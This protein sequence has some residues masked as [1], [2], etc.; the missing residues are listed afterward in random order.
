M[1]NKYLKIHGDEQLYPL[2]GNN[3]D[4]NNSNISKGR[5]VICPRAAK[6][7]YANAS[8]VNNGDGTFGKPFNDI[9]SAIDACEDGVSTDIVI[10]G[11]FRPE[12]TLTVASGKNINIIGN[13]GSSIR[14]SM[15]CSKYSRNCTNTN[16]VKIYV[17]EICPQWIFVDGKVRYP[18]STNRSSL[19]KLYCASTMD[20]EA[21]TMTTTIRIY[22]ADA[23]KIA[24]TG[25]KDSWITILFKWMSYK[26]RIQ[27]I[28]VDTGD[29]VCVQ[30]VGTE[31]GNV[32]HKMNKSLRVIFENFNIPGCKMFG[33]KDTWQKG[34]YYVHEGYLYYKLTDDDDVNCDIEIPRTEV[35]ISASGECNIYNVNICHSNHVFDNTCYE[36]EHCGYSG[37]QAC[38]RFNGAIEINGVSK[39]MN[40]TFDHTTNH[41]I[42]LLNNAHDCVISNNNFRELG[43]SSIAIGYV[44]L[45]F[46][47]TIPTVCPDNVLFDN[48]VI[49][50][51]ARIY[52]GAC[53]V[54]VFYGSNYRI[55]HNVICD[56]YY[57]GITTGYTWTSEV[58]ANKNGVIENNLL[59]L[60]GVGVQALFDGGAFY[61]L[62]NSNGLTI[63]NNIINNVYGDVD[64]IEK[65]DGLF[66]DESSANITV[67]NNLFFHCGKFYRF[68]SNIKNV[69]IRNNIFVDDFVSVS[70]RTLGY[71]TNNIFIFNNAPAA[72]SLNISGNLWY[73]ADGTDFIITWDRNPTK[74]NPFVDY[75][76]KDYRIANTS[77]TEAIGFKVF[78][79]NLALRMNDA[80]IDK[81]E[82][83][84]IINYLN[85]QWNGNLPK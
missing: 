57:T 37:R 83:Q 67:E 30:K 40:C 56:T 22:K 32:L 58:N 45:D 13:A 34:T 17:G 73:M 63:R 78:E 47:K 16:W 2:G 6:T 4:G 8:V 64:S 82:W 74:G 77:L 31:G 69:N 38:A 54:T 51:P 80:K 14:G 15:L 84:K 46:K 75:E 35:L 70:T 11:V 52:A 25:Y 7:L 33:N 42:K 65:L 62:G 12:K 39:I 36:G 27:S 44:P 26:C 60:I 85:S 68:N 21:D 79:P 81:E 43:C 5:N 50:S 3:V 61:N 10:D 48:N 49:V 9:Q 20:T 41:A 72:N 76:N 71:V 59:D 29:L 55:S 28:N 18:A 23:Q 1:G 66:C 53:G 19:L 24:F